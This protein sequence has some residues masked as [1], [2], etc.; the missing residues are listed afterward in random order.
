MKQATVYVRGL[1]Y[2]LR[3]IGIPVD[4]PSF[5]FGN[6][7]S[8]LVNTTRPE[9]QLKKTQSIPYHHVCK[10]CAKDEWHTSYVNM[11]ENVADLL[12]K[13]LPSGEK[14]WKFVGMLLHHLSPKNPDAGEATGQDI[15]E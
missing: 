1:H 5:I 6:N 2:K 4:E 3:M 13:P 8:I 10:G 7:Q 14:R 12:T 11:H 9:S 15:G